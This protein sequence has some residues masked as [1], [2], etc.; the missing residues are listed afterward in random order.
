[1][2]T[3]DPYDVYAFNL[4]LLQLK[5]PELAE[6]LD[7]VDIDGIQHQTIEGKSCT[8]AIDGRQLT[9]RHDPEAEAALRC[10]SLNPAESID[11]YG[12]ECGYS[13]R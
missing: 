4:G 1:M 5:S 10:A 9:S 2:N 13:A 7:N 12:F 6:V 8:L 11:I 3:D